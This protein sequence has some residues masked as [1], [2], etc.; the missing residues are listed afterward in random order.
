MAT[1][2]IPDAGLALTPHTLT[3]LLVEDNDGDAALLEASLAEACTGSPL[4]P[5]VSLRRARTLED[6]IRQLS[7]SRPAVILLDLGLPDSSGIST[8]LELRVACDLPIVVLTGL[9]DET[10]ALEALQRGAQD[11]LF[12]NEL[13]PAVT[14][15]TLRYAIERRQQEDELAHTRWRAGIGDTVLAVLHEI[16]NPLT[17]LLMNAEI[18]AAGERDSNTVEAVREAAAR[19]AEVTRRLSRQQVE[20]R[21]VEYV[22][23][24]KMLDLR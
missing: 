18:L 17:S 16:N 8:L 10:V 14:L 5:F 11:Y 4:R 22:R 24:M 1:L 7:E 19:I 20:P 9:A 15:R 2:A 13:S 6:A 23:G 12:K 3:L 21:T